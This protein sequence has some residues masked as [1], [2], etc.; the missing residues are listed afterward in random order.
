MPAEPRP[1]I[2][3][4]TEGLPRHDGFLPFYW[5]GQAGMLLLEIV[6][7]DDEFLYLWGLTTGAGSVDV[8]LDRGSV[9]G[10]ALARWR[11]AG[12]RVLLELSNLRFRAE[13]ENAELARSV[14]ESFAPAVVAA[15]PLVAEEDGRL[16]VDATPLLVRDVTDVAGAIKRASLG[17]VKLDEARSGPALEFCKGFPFNTELE[18]ALTF[19]GKDLS[20]KLANCW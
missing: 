7:P 16:L 2:S 14:R 10:S 11:P 8:G 4:R 15:L 17:E 6:R 9:I 1:S 20:P 18:A 13:T 3:A 19:T 12:P 5:D